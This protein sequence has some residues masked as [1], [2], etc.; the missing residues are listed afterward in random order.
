MSA[1]SRPAVS[2]SPALAAKIGVPGD[3]DVPALVALIN[4]LAAER[5]QLFIQ[6]VDPVTGIAAVRAHLA[7]IAL[8]GA[9]TVL[10]ARDGYELVGLI[11]GTR[12]GHPARR[13]VIDIGIGVRASHRGK[14]IGFALLT[15]LETWA[16]NAGCH[17]LQLHVVTG[18][19]P[20]IAL[21]RKAGFAVE[22]KLEATAMLDGETLDEFEMGKLIGP[23]S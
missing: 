13:G 11:T 6:P 8:S 15:A 14:G 20:A 1:L 23:P 10:V 19:A 9:E 16:R 5:N 22:G 18:N 12:G 2:P 3:D 17:R 7:A 21:Y 4:A